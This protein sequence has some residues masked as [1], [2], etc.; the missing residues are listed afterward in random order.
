M[1]NM[2]HRKRKYLE[3][4][5]KNL[6]FLYYPCSIVP[7]YLLKIKSL[8]FRSRNSQ[9]L[10]TNS[11]KSDQ[12]VL[13]CRK[14]CQILT[15]ARRKFHEN[16]LCDCSRIM[17]GFMNVTAFLSMWLSNTATT[18]MMVPIAHAILR[19][20]GQ[21]LKCVQQERAA[22]LSKARKEAAAIEGKLILF[23][24]HIKISEIYIY[25]FCCYWLADGICQYEHCR[26]QWCFIQF[27][28]SSNK[29]EKACVI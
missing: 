2:I 7:A 15:L 19:E 23:F 29:S 21:H 12:C 20:L 9:K 17:F 25:K 6:S 14:T 26:V 4:T 18:A 5:R 1:K 22:A 27:T 8:Q 10:G 3:K 16:S 28:T 11:C 24:I 13:S